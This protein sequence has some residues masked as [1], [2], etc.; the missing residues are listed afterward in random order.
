MVKH[1][2]ARNEERKER[3]GTEEQ[4]QEGGFHSVGL[5]T[6]QVPW[7]SRQDASCL[8]SFR[9]FSL[10]VLGTSCRMDLLGFAGD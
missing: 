9:T 1:K 4:P 2:K 10:C 8:R 7:Q 3:K 6:S 5:G